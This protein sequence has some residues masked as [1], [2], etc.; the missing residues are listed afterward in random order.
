[1]RNHHCAALLLPAALLSLS[2]V[3]A[4]VR[5]QTAPP[6]DAKPAGDKAAAPEPTRSTTK[7][8]S[9]KT[10]A[11]VTLDAT[12]LTLTLRDRSDK[13]TEYTLT[14]KTRYLKN[15]TMVQPDAFK[16]GDA[17]T[18]RLRKIRNQNAY[19]VFELTDAASG[20]W[21]RAIRRD[22][23]PATIK[24]IEEER[25]SVVGADATLFNYVL[26]E[27]TRWSKGGKEATARDFKPGNKVYVV[28]RSLPNGD[29]MAR[30]VADT[31][32]GAAQ[33]KERTAVTV[34]G[35]VQNVDVSAHKFVLATKAGDTRTL[36]YTDSTEVHQ[37]G[38][39]LPLTALKAGLSVGAHVKH[40]VDGEDV[41]SRITI[42]ASTGKNVRT[43][44]KTATSA[45]SA[46]DV[47]H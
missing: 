11:I 20:N 41:A 36:H 28:P 42:D 22:T 33:M 43:H 4:F 30:A 6:S 19:A 32:S 45:P 7:S 18:I 40:D 2:L 17:V 13:T 27:K 23:V 15:K 47:G 5:A 24:A 29:I 25:L 39:T 21:L 14:P 38:K 31:P 12:G 37:S 8:A 44:K 34:H 16:A 35:V 1:M 3:P 9:I 26:T 46:P 10:G